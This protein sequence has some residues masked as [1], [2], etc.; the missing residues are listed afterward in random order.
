MT[1]AVLEKWRQESCGGDLVPVDD[2]DLLDEL[3]SDS[4]TGGDRTPQ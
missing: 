2:G 4:M 3:D 1:E